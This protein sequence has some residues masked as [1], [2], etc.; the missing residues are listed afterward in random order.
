MKSIF[1]TSFNALKRALTHDAICDKARRLRCISLH[2]P[3]SPYI[4][5]ASP[6]VSLHL[7][8]S[9]YIS[10]H[11]AASPHISLSQVRPVRER[12][13]LVLDEVHHL[14]AP[15]RH[16]QPPRPKPNTTYPSP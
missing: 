16:L 4:S 10:L 6:Y 11:L 9:P 15:T 2:L 3:T 12:I 7:P 1:I 8:T 5:P 13:L 14:P